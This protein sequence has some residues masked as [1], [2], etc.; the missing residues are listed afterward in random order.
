MIKNLQIIEV[1]TVNSD[2]EDFSILFLTSFY[3][4]EP[5][6]LSPWY[7]WERC[8][9]KK[10]NNDKFEIYIFMRINIWQKFLFVL[11][12]VHVEPTHLLNVTGIDSH[13]DKH[14]VL[15]YQPPV[16]SI[17]IYLYLM[18]I[19][20]IKWWNITLDV[21]DGCFWTWQ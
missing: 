19:N 12:Q 1:Q 10:I 7:D 17:L 9:Q 20:G 14:Q 4:P 5:L 18:I 6:C 3:H 15:K 13:I 2:F 11:F 8:V 21:T 16:T